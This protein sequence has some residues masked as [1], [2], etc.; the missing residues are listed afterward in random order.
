M[1]RTFFNLLRR[2]EADMRVFEHLDL[3]QYDQMMEVLQKMDYREFGQLKRNEMTLIHN[4]VFDYE[5]LQH[6]STLPYFRD[7]VNDD[8]NPD[9]WTPLMWCQ[10]LNA[11]DIRTLKFLHENGA[12]MLHRKRQTGSTLLH[13]FAAMGKL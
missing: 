4:A 1:R 5:A 13:M 7:Y 11:L 2:G 3:G 9:Q 8:N 12:D 10:K 6:L